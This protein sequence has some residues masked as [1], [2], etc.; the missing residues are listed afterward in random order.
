MCRR[1]LVHLAC[2]SSGGTIRTCR[3]RDQS[4]CPLGG[5]L[6][7]AAA[8]GGSGWAAWPLVGHCLGPGIIAATSGSLK[9]W[10]FTAACCFCFSRTNIDATVGL[11]RFTGREGYLRMVSSW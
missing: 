9:C 4:S 7:S 1:Q 5:R 3:V 2:G 11:V 8:A 10:I 6:C